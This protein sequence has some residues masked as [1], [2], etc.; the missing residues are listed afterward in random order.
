MRR[1]RPVTELLSGLRVVE[2]GME[3]REGGPER[4]PRDPVAG[5]GEARER[6]LQ[7]GGP[8]EAVRLSDAAVG[9]HELRGHRRAQR[10]L[11]LV[12]DGGE[13][14]YAALDEE[15][16]H[17]PFVVLR[18]DDRDVGD[19]AVGDPGLLARQDPA[20]AV[21]PG[22]GPHRAGVGAEVRL[23]EAE[24][25]DRLAAGEEG[26]P[27]VLLLLRPPGHDRVHHERRL[28]G[29]ER[30]Q[31]RVAALQLLHHE[32]VRDVGEAR[33][34]VFPDRRAEEVELSHL[35]DQ[36]QREARLPGPLLDARQDALAHP[37]VNGVAHHSLLVREEVVQCEEIQALVGHR[38]SLRTNPA[39]PR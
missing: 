34:A 9:E 32:P 1:D 18:P 33:E 27:A 22:A 5:L 4:A 11:S 29:D 10:V 23:G 26:D 21:A 12:L 28:D 31:A 16:S 8:A 17:E 36:L 30:A 6:A 37:V 7:P 39:A 13:P 3:R 38:V 25:P 19:R 15:P 2:G 24:A 35:R 20:V 14:R